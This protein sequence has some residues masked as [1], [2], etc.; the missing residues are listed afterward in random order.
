MTDLSL[1]PSGFRAWRLEIWATWTL[2]EQ[3]EAIEMNE[4]S[5]YHTDRI[6]NNP[7]QE[8]IY[9]FM[10]Y[11]VKTSWQ[12]QVESYTNIDVILQY[13]EGILAKT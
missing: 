9:H 3:K 2:L 6:N 8:I 10:F 13:L 11:F 12:I 1:Q 7:E 5:Y 4:V